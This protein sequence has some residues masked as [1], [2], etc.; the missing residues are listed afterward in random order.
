MDEVEIVQAEL[1]PDPIVDDRP[2]RWRELLV[3]LA[4]VALADVTIYRGY[5]YSGY[6]VLFLA[7]RSCCFWACCHVSFNITATAAYQE[8][9]D[10]CRLAVRLGGKNGLVWLGAAQCTGSYAAVCLCARPVRYHSLCAR[11]HCL[12]I[13]DDVGRV[14]G[15]GG[16]HAQRA[17][18]P[19]WRIARIGFLSIALPLAAF[20]AFSLLFILANPDL[21]DSFGQRAEK[22][23]T[24]FREWLI[25]FSPH[26]LEMMFWLAIAW[27]AI[28]MLR[29]MLSRPLF[30]GLEIVERD[31]KD[32]AVA[33]TPSPLY[34]AARNTLVTVLVLF[35]IY[36]VFEFKTLWFRKFP[37]G[38][39]YSGYA[40]QGAAWL[41]VALALATIVL[42]LVFRGTVLRDPRLK[43]LRRIAWLWSLENVLL[44]LAV[45]H[46]LH[47]YVGFNGMTRMR[48]VGILG[49][50][51]V[52]IGFLLVLW[53]I[54]RNRGFLWLVRRHLWTVAFAVYLYGVLPVDSIVVNYNV[55]RILAGD[56][57]PS[58]QI[59]EHEI[60]SEGVL[61]LA[62]LLECDDAVVREG[63][64]AYLAD[65]YEASEALYERRQDKAGQH[66][67]V[68]TICCSSNCVPTTFSWH[69]IATLSCGNKRTTC[70]ERTRTSGIDASY[71]FTASMRH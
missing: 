12:S 36:L 56:S 22:I 4:I 17:R 49:I 35:A 65:R 64:R 19:R 29:P 69:P 14:V 39:Y 60:S 28:G 66:F 26:P 55:Q 9:V 63:V 71:P 52:L 3:V 5:G 15:S 67:N 62:P 16:V 38:F 7:R 51:A 8:S 18:R 48:I 54:A 2:V 53:K 1:V 58:V 25:D 10:G 24:A 50:S 40:H 11:D 33:Q 68:R 27:I 43:T 6:A 61:L 20:I 32:V 41:T 57:A 46:R 13:A 42:S 21:L 31:S 34:A 30:E 44:A 37:D 59:T 70:S 45:Y 47:I 23:L